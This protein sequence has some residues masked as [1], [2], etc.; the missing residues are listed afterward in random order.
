MYC[1]FLDISVK[2]FVLERIFRNCFKNLFPSRINT[3]PLKP[4]RCTTCNETFKERYQLK[5]HEARHNLQTHKA[6]CN[7]C[8]KGFYTVEDLGAH[9][10]VHH[11]QNRFVCPECKQSFPNK[12]RLKTHQELCIKKG[13]EEENLTCKI[14]KKPFTGKSHLTKHLQMHAADTK[15]HKCEQCNEHFYTVREFKK[16]L[17]SHRGVQNSCP[18]CNRTFSD[19]RNFTRHVKTHREDYVKKTFPCD[20]C[21][22]VCESNGGLKQHMNNGHKKIDYTCSVCGKLLSSSQNLEHHLWLHTQG[23]LFTCGIC[24]TGFGTKESLDKHEK[25][26]HGVEE[27]FRCQ[28]CDKTFD[29][30]WRMIMHM[31][32]HKAVF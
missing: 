22:K 7:H 28:V 18:H 3:P 20:I 2:L 27:T 8:D 14:C 13:L 21:G 15:P 31:R 5:Y 1:E 17:A 12:N 10:A 25:G 6:K 30:R 23:K 26:A 4:F 32:R 16:H 19:P 9:C 24:K 11:K 29:K